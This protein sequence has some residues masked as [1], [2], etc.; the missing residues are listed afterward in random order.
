MFGKVRNKAS[1]NPVRI[2][3]NEHAINDSQQDL[4]KP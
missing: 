1:G 3:T 2:Y 4:N